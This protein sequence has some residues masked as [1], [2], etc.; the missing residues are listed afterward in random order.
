[1]VFP[2]HHRHIVARPGQGIWSDPKAKG[3]DTR[4]HRST[5]TDRIWQTLRPS[6]T[7]I[8]HAPNEGRRGTEAASAW[9]SVGTFRTPAL[10]SRGSRQVDA[11]LKQKRGLG[12]GVI[13]QS[14]DGNSYKPYIGTRRRG[15]PPTIEFV[16]IDS[17]HDALRCPSFAD[18]PHTSRTRPP[19]CVRL[20]TRKQLGTCLCS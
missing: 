5:S 7:P 8:R 1:M 14:S 2:R 19:L 12:K 3:T 20:P 16:R 17:G 18:N 4:K 6:T 11:A 15:R 10:H 9:I 13:G